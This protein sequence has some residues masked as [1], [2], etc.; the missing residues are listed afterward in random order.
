MRFWKALAFGLVLFLSAGCASIVGKSVFPVT[1]H[2][3]P[4][5]SD[6]LIKDEKGQEVFAGTTP[7]TVTLDAGE[8]YFHAKSYR[9]TFSKAGYASHQEVIRAQLSGW[10]I[11]NAL[12]G[13]FIGWLIVDPITG[14]MWKLPTHVTAD[15]SPGGPP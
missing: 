2:S 7:T 3:D 10:Y 4:S 15:L 8:A 5:G 11:G 13:G 14:K 9:V 12:F 6:I 1:I